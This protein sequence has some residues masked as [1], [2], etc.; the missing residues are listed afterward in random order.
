MVTHVSVLNG[1][2]P[3]NLDNFF[4]NKYRIWAHLESRIHFFSRISGAHFPCQA[5]LACYL[6]DN[7]NHCQCSLFWSGN[8]QEQLLICIYFTIWSKCLIL[9]SYFTYLTDVFEPAENTHNTKGLKTQY[10]PMS[11]HLMTASI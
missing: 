9:L 4:F 10:C 11:L 2:A 8:L 7:H 5:K 3:L 1:I 6:Q